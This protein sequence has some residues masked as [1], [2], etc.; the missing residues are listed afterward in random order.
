MLNG[1]SYVEMRVRDFDA[2]RHVY[3]EG[4]GLDEV[5][6]GTGAGGAQVWVFA[7]GTSVLQIYED[8]NAVTALLPSGEPK[9]RDDVPGS[10][11]HMAFYAESNEDAFAALKGFLENS[12][13]STRDGPQ[14]QPMDHAYMQ[15]TL[16]EFKDPSGYVV[17]IADVVDPRSHLEERRAAKRKAALPGRPG[18]LRGFD[19]L[20]I[21]CSDVRA[22]RDLFGAALGA[23]EI[24]HRSDEQGEESVFAVGLTDLE[25]S[26]ASAPTGKRFGP[27]IVTGVGFWTDDVRRAYETLNGKGV[28]VGGP[29]S[30]RSPLPAIRREGFTFEGLDGLPLEVVQGPDG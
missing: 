15:R 26:Q 6:H 5:A 28:A 9:D 22:A 4:L 3:G 13:K 14:L 25:I 27:G 16:L 8:P 30:D 12:P 10:V 1:V 17:Q 18:L 19:H 20:N 24:S 29:P 11:G 2:Y 23:E 7:L 21:S